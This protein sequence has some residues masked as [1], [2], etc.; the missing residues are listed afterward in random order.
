MI[1][2]I[3]EAEPQYI[4]NEIE[5]QAT[6]LA[7]G[8]QPEISDFS[9]ESDEETSLALFRKQTNENVFFLT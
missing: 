5:Q 8:K 7:L 1:I 3:A 2:S 4:R 9:T 6:A